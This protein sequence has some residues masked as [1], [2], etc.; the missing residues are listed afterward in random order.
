MAKTR[1]QHKEKMPP[2]VPIRM[3]M[4]ES[5]AYQTLPPS[6]AKL[7]PYFIRTCIRV[8][9]GAP[10]TSTIFGFTYTEAEKCGFA[11]NTFTRAVK[12]LVLH[13]FIDLVEAGGLRGAGHT[14][15]KYK[16]S[17]QW[18]GYGGLDWAKAAH[19]EQ[20]SAKK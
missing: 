18:V 17:S 3:D 7:L 2:F 10:D 11:V 14:C 20:Q 4:L 19:K 13:G 16:L 1:Q 15:S 12:A 6:A 8:I 9:R 5:T